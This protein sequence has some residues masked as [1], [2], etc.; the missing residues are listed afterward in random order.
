MHSLKAA[1]MKAYRVFRPL[2]RQGLR[3]PKLT[4]RMIR[5]ADAKDSRVAFVLFLSWPAILGA[6]GVLWALEAAAQRGP[7]DAT[8]WLFWTDRLLKALLAVLVASFS[9]WRSNRSWRWRRRLRMRRAAVK[10]PVV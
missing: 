9:I 5:W 7:A 4:K 1:A 8:P 10:Y 3:S 2:P 6:A